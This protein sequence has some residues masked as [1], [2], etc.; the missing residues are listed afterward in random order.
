MLLMMNIFLM[1][2]ESGTWGNIS[3]AGEK[4]RIIAVFI[5]LGKISDSGMVVFGKLGYGLGANF[6]RLSDSQIMLPS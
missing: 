6:S 5:P 3:L 4:I 1:L 2:K